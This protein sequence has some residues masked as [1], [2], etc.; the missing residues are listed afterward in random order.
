MKGIK[1]NRL[2]IRFKG[3]P[4]RVIHN[5]MNGLGNELL[6]RF[7]QQGG[8]LTEK[9]MVKIETIDSGNVSMKR[10][11]HYQDLRRMMVNKIA[12]AV[13]QKIQKYKEEG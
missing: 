5:S 13:S 12:G 8:L 4:H 3:I 10:E 11:I 1:I 2:Q 7:S 9:G 6:A